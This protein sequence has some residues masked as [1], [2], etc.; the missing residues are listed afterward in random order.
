MGESAEMSIF[1]YKEYFMEEEPEEYDQELTEEERAQFERELLEKAYDNT[2]RMLTEKITL[3]ELMSEEGILGL[4]ALLAYDPKRGIR[5]HELEG[6]I[7]YYVDMEEYEKC[8]KLKKILNEKY[9]ETVID[10][11]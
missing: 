11:N 9:P 6:T 7:D 5:K 4:T 8:A 1:S 3:D 2:Y 10:N